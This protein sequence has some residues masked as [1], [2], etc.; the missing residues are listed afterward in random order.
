MH[1]LPQFQ[2]QSLLCQLACVYAHAKTH[3][4]AYVCVWVVSVFVAS[5]SMRALKKIIHIGCEPY[6]EYHIMISA[7]P[8]KEIK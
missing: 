5:E 3:I 8:G 7:C 2:K 4:Y 1:F 6:H